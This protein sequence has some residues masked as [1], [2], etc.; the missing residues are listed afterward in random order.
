LAG[1]FESIRRFEILPLHIEESHPCGSASIKLCM[2]DGR[3]LKII[4]HG[5]DVRGVFRTL[6]NLFL[7]FGEVRTQIPFRENAFRFWE[8]VRIQDAAD[9]LCETNSIIWIGRTISVGMP[10][11]KIERQ[12]MGSTVIQKNLEVGTAVVGKSFGVTS[13][14]ERGVNGFQGAGCFFIQGVGVPDQKISG[15]FQNSQYIIP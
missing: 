1:S 13:N 5:S 4:Q 14:L 8:S 11:V 2:V 6:Q 7:I 15:S 10:R 12:L 9:L 3:I